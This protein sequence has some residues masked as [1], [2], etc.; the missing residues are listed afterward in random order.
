MMIE[1][2]PGTAFLR[3]VWAA[4]GNESVAMSSS[5]AARAVAAPGEPA[6]FRNETVYFLPYSLS[7]LC[8]KKSCWKNSGIMSFGGGAMYDSLISTGLVWA[9]TGVQASML[10]AMARSRSGADTEKE[11]R[12]MFVRIVNE[13]PWRVWNGRGA[14]SPTGT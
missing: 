3:I 6:T 5:P 14:R 7:R 8:L 9:A 4:T 13:P 11:T 1:I 2:P 12:Q 10:A